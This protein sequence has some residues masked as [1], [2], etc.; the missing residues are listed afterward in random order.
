[1]L[2]RLVEPSETE[3]CEMYLQVLLWFKQWDTCVFGSEI[4]STVDEVLSALR[5]H[6][7]ITHHKAA[8]NPITL[9][10][11]RGQGQQWSKDRFQHPQNSYSRDHDAKTAS[12]KWGK[13]S[14]ITGPPEQKVQLTIY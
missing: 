14:R 11:N 10:N 5:R 12:E 7:S 4:R 9:K 2:S 13:N 3:F 1:M 6:S 8:G